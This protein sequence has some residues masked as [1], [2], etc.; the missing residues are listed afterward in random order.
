MRSK[1]RIY[2]ASTIILLYMSVSLSISEKDEAKS[3]A[4]QSA[5]YK[6]TRIQKYKNTN[7]QEFIFLK[8]QYKNSIEKY[9][10]K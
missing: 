7:I 3:L 9:T 5:E 4:L 6:N 10:I 8:A 1:S 2:R